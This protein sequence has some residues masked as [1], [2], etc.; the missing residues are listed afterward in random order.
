MTQDQFGRLFPEVPERTLRYRTRRLHKLGLTGRSRPYRERGSAPNHHWPTRRADCLVR[1]EPL[2]RGGERH[3][4]DPVFLAHAAALSELYVTLATRAPEMGLDLLIYRREGQARESFEDGARARTL[5]P[6]ATVV[7]IDGEER[8]LGAFVEIDLGTMSHTRLRFK[9]GLYAAYARSGVWREQHLF[10]PELLFLTTTPARAS[11][12]V[13]ALQAALQG[14][15]QRSGVRSRTAFVAAAGAFALTLGRLVEDGSLVDLDGREGL[16]LLDVLG[17]ARAPYEEKRAYRQAREQAEA[18]EQRRLLDDAEALRA[19]LHRKERYLSAYIDAFAPGGGLAVRLLL[20][21]SGQP[22]PVERD[23]LQAIGR[24]LGDALLEPGA[25]VLSAPGA[26]VNSEAASLADCYRAAQQE[27]LEA[28][29]S[30][31]GEGPRLREAGERLRSGPLIEGHVLRW[32]PREAEQDAVC[33]QDQCERRGAYLAWRERAARQL[34]RKAGPLGRLTHHAEDFYPQLD[35]R[36][37]GFCRRCQEITYPE[38]HA[39]GVRNARPACHYCH[40]TDPVEAYHG[41][42]PAS[43]EREVRL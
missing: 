16:S 11:K 22:Q 27:R 10:L 43:T 19:H 36:S 41:D 31:Y 9:A 2:P 23:V 28:L 39:A 40:E 33:R 21:S 29:A 32:L 34:A 18:Q 30:R 20:A 37:L 17:D 42:A 4:R 15:G 5:A 14:S 12:F 8:K 3:A 24:D 13:K 7:L 6:D 35:Q 1:G 25:S 38:A 26:A